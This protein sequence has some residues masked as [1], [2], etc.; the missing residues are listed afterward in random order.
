MLFQP[1]SMIR[2]SATIMLWFV[3][4]EISVKHNWRF[5]AYVLRTYTPLIV[6]LMMMMYIVA[7]QVVWILYLCVNITYLGKWNCNWVCTE[8]EGRHLQQGW[9][10]WSAMVSWMSEAWLP[11]VHLYLST[12]TQTSESYIHTNRECCPSECNTGGFKA[13][14]RVH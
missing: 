4:I 9:S 11:S 13:R 12:Q 1:Y 14:F 3:P 2:H 5:S 10:S 8:S 6:L 7:G